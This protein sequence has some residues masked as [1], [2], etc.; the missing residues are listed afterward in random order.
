MATS[1]KKR[2]FTFKH[3]LYEHRTPEKLKQKHNLSENT[4]ESMRNVLRLVDLRGLNLH[5][6][7]KANILTKLK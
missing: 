7:I 1:E 2:Q 6:P 4:W 5:K 3:L